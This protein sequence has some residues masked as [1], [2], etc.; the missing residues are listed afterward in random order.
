MEI[1]EETRGHVIGRTDVD[2]FKTYQASETDGEDSVLSYIVLF[3]GNGCQHQDEFNAF[4][5]HL[6]S[7]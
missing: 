7:L 1:Q 3:A 4:L 2:K 6:T 5:V